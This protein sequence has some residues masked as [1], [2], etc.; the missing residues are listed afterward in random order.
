MPQFIAT[1]TDGSTFEGGLA[2]GSFRDIDQTRLR[3]FAITYEGI[4]ASLDLVTGAFTV[5]G[6]TST[7]PIAPYPRL[8]AYQTNVGGFGVPERMY[9]FVVGWQAT[10]VSEGKLRNIKLGL[11]VIPEEDRWEITEAI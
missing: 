1:Y 4:V 2:D 3:S 5:N 11:R 8:I 6:S 9:A 10:V 7:P